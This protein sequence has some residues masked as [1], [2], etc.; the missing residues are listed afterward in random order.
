[1]SI[2][3]KINK[4]EIPGRPLSFFDALFGKCTAF[5]DDFM[6][7]V[8]TSERSTHIS[9]SLPFLKCIYQLNEKYFSTKEKFGSRN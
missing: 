4:S 3:S 8:V 6:V 7:D 2:T 1:M 9:P 5:Y